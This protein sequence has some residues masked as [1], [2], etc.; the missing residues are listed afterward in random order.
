M[1]PSFEKVE[2]VFASFEKVEIL[3][4]LLLL[5]MVFF[6]FLKLKISLKLESD[7]SN[8]SLDFFIYSGSCITSTRSLHSL[9]PR[10]PHRYKEG[11]EL[12]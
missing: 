7:N 6:L 1:L 3:F 12:Y 11:V 8:V 10:L 2:I 9:R 4:F 5:I